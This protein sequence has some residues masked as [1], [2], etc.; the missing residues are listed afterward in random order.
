MFEIFSLFIVVKK[1]RKKMGFPEWA[2]VSVWLNQELSAQYPDP[3]VIALPEIKNLDIPELS[4]YEDNA[5]EEFWGKFPKRELPAT[6]NTRVNTTAF[7]RRIFSARDKMSKTEYNRAKRALRNLQKGAN[8]FQ[9][10][11]LPPISVKNSESTRIYGK[12]LTDTIATWVKKGFVAGPFETP[13]VPGFRAN[14]LGVV[15][16]NGKVRPILNMSGPRGTSFNDNVEESK[17]EKLHMGT[18]KEFS[19]LLRDAGIGAKFSKFDIQDAYKLVPAQT[20]DFRLQGFQ[21]L[22]RYFVETRLSFGGKPSPVNFDSLGKTKDLLVC[23]ETGTP[24]YLVPRALDDSPCVGAAGSGIVERFTEGMKS[25]CA[26]LNIPLAANCP[27]AEKAFELVQRGTVLGVGFDSTDMTWFLS[28][29]KADKIVRRCLDANRS[30]HMSLKQVQQLMGSVNDLAQMCPL[31][32]PHKRS[33]NEFLTKFGGDGNILKMVP[34]E[35]RRD[36]KVIAKV[37][38]SA[39]IG[40]PIAEKIGKPGLAALTFY[41]DAAGASF[42]LV[43]KQRHYHDNEGKGVACIG[44]TCIEDIWGWSRL[45]WPGMLITGQV[46]EKGCSFGSKSTTLEAVGILIPLLAFKQKVSGKEIIF[47]VD[48]MAVTWGWQ[49]GYV[50]GDKTASEILKAARYLAGFLGTTI[51][52]EHVDRMSSEMASLADELSRRESCKDP[53]TAEKLK[54]AYFSPVTGFL[55]QWLQNPKE[56]EDLCMKLLEENCEI[57]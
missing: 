15:V 17:L 52:I 49:K 37:A 41:T 16:R 30:S 14:P 50:K 19:F 54:E 47:K 28:D 1:G 31:L 25:M 4:S 5:S 7:K 3:E 35:V 32:K 39:R 8:S 55:M 6:V 57:V 20:E 9:K 18:A 22:G 42:S 38:N 46:D 34:D 48:N 11:P 10:A 44:G 24:R 27:R 2:T 51:Y 13:P 33:G 36:L 43:N 56:S 21:W 53:E 40:L 23:L 45:S 26:D 29:E 12:Y